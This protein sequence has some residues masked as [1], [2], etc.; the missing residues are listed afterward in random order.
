MVSVDLKVYCNNCP[1]FEPAASKNY[2]DN[3]LLYTSVKCEN[4]QK[5]D[6]IEIYLRCEMEKEDHEQNGNVN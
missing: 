5:C 3:R 6:S 1:H 4:K 2:A